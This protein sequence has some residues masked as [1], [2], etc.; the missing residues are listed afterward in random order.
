MAKQ[1]CRTLNECLEAV[2]QKTANTYCKT[3]L[4]GHDTF[5]NLSDAQLMCAADDACTGVADGS[6]NG[7]PYTLC[8]TITSSTK[9]ACTWQKDDF[10]QKTCSDRGTCKDGINEYTCICDDGFGGADCER[11]TVYCSAGQA[12]SRLENECSPCEQGTTVCVRLG[13]SIPGAAT[14][15]DVR[16]CNC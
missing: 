2:Q 13:E 6:C 16:E 1:T 4:A 10:K 11:S 9:G 5:G 14:A 8:A 12:Y 15:K 3:N 7:A